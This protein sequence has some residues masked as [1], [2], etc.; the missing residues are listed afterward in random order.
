MDLSVKQSLSNISL[1]VLIFVILVM[2]RSSHICLVILII[3]IPKFAYSNF[4]GYKNR[5]LGSSRI[6]EDFKDLLFLTRPEKTQLEFSSLH[7]D[8]VLLESECQ[9]GK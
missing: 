5:P 4:S 6:S 8:I 2:L 3:N 7:V 9:G 1:N